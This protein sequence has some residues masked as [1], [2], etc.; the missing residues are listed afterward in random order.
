MFIDDLFAGI[1]DVDMLINYTIYYKLF[2]YTYACREKSIQLL[3]GTNFVP[4][5]KQFHNLPGKK[6]IRERDSRHFNILFMC[7][8]GDPFHVLGDILK[9]GE[10]CGAIKENNF[11]LVAGAYHPQIS[12]LKD[13]ERRHENIYLHQ[14]VTDMAGLMQQCDIAVSAAGTT[15]Y[16]CCAVGLPT[17]FF[18]MVDNQQHDGLC[19]SR[20][21]L[22]LYAGDL[23]FQKEESIQNIFSHISYLKTNSGARYMMG[24]RLKKLV[25]GNGANRI[26]EEIEKLW[27]K[28]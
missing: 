1:Y 25:D 26:A 14:N 18:C 6:N 10:K 20:D 12:L 4:L 28:N 15:L 19:F 5:R 21:A 7:G 24:Q 16:E 9:Y 23:R 22:M 17:I 2:N 13:W 27:N 11:H 8:G 3:L